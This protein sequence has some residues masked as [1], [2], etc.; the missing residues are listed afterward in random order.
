MVLN[1]KVVNYKGVDLFEYYNFVIKFVFS[2]LDLK[3]L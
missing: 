1:E 3:K 2:Q